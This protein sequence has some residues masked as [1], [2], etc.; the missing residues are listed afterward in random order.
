MPLRTA[1]RWGLALQASALAWPAAWRALAW[2]MGAG[3][4]F[5]VLNALLRGLALQLHPMQT[6]FLRYLFG[7]VVLLPLLLRGAR[8]LWPQRPG[9]QLW[10]GAVHT[11]GL[12]L[13]F[14]ALPHLPLA[15]TTAIGFTTP[16]FILLGAALFLGE[17]LRLARWVATGAGFAGMLLVLGPRLGGS[18]GGAWHLLMLA[19]APVFAASFLITKALTRHEQT[20]VIVLWQA[21]T[22]TLFSLPAALWVWQWPLPLQ[23]AGFALCGALGS[24]GHYCLTRSFRAAEISATQ[25]VKFLELLWSA[26]LGWWLFSEH[27]AASTLAGGAVIALATLWLARHEGRSGAGGALPPADAEGVRKR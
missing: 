10:R 14:L 2:S 6:Q 25:S 19:S 5:T 26:L 24:A 1:R 7:F 16:L 12:V 21:L 22:V 23:W 27:P 20:S 11:L 17:R 13:W 18:G 9:G 8:T 15:D 3:L 4:L